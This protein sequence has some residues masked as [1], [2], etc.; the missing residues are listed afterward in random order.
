MNKSRLS[1]R[2]L[3]SYFRV[4]VF[5]LHAIISNWRCIGQVSVP[6]LCVYIIKKKRADQLFERMLLESATLSIAIFIWRKASG[7]VHDNVEEKMDGGSGVS[8][9][10]TEASR[11]SF[12]KGP[13]LSKMS[14]TFSTVSSWKMHLEHLFYFSIFS[15]YGE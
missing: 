8:S 7:E 4:Q 15:E 3:E 12:A 5:I 2:F 1:I 13:I 6:V 9:S 14:T 10:S 11:Y